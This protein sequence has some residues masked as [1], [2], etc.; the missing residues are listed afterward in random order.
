MIN[1]YNCTALCK[2]SNH[3]SSETASD[4]VNQLSYLLLSLRHVTSR[5][6]GEVMLHPPSTSLTF[7][8]ISAMSPAGRM[9]RSSSR[10][11][12]SLS[13]SPRSLSCHQY[14]GWRDISSPSSLSL[15]TTP[16]SLSCHQSAGWR[17]ISSPSSFSL[18]PTPRSP[19]CNQS[20][21][22]KWRGVSLPSSLSHSPRSPSYYQQA[23]WLG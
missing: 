6:Q 22:W 8:P 9:V 13:P 3:L 18:S 14:A 16:R 11:S 19:S 1:Y 5:Q 23:E 21:G 2:W 10:P 7:S 17:D 15:S 20:A 12:L 4:S